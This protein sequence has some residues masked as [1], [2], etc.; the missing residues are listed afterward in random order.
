MN[1]NKQPTKDIGFWQLTSERIQIRNI[2]LSLSESNSSVHAES[3]PLSHQAVKCTAWRVRQATG[4]PAGRANKR[5]TYCFTAH[6]APV[7]RTN[8]VLIQ[9]DIWNESTISTV[10]YRHWKNHCKDPI[11]DFVIH[12]QNCYVSWDL[13]LMHN[14]SNANIRKEIITRMSIPRSSVWNGPK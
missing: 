9:F 12:N 11:S 2:L 5:P 8:A 13:Q 1:I 14:S 10:T 6:W 7:F 4:N 3:L